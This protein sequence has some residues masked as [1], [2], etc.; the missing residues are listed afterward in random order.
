M[1]MPERNETQPKT[2]PL[3]DSEAEKGIIS[4]AMQDYSYFSQLAGTG[5]NA[6]W[7]ASHEASYLWSA[8]DEL[9]QP[10]A[11]ELTTFALE[12]LPALNAMPEKRRSAILDYFYSAG[13][14]ATPFSQ[15]E[16]YYSK[17][18]KAYQKRLLKQAA[19]NLLEASTRD[20]E[21][22]K[23]LHDL[24]ETVSKVR[25]VATPFEV[26]HSSVLAEQGIEYF[27]K[28]LDRTVNENFM[29][30]EQAGLNNVTEGGMRRGEMTLIKAVTSAGKSSL[31]QREAYVQA[32]K[33]NRCVIYFS[34]EM[35]RFKWLARS[36][37]QDMGISSV[38]LERGKFG[39]WKE[40]VFNKLN[41]LKGTRL[42]LV[43]DTET[44]LEVIKR[45]CE[46]VARKEGAIDIVVVDYAQL[47]RDDT[48]KT[49]VERN[50]RISAALVA[51]KN[52][53]NCHVIGIVKLSRSGE[54]G[55]SSY[56]EY[57]ADNIWLLENEVTKE[58]LPSH[59]KRGPVKVTIQKQRYA[60]SGQEVELYYNGA[61]SRFTDV[62][63]PLALP[64]TYYN[65]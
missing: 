27:S 24:E 47:V 23:D 39:Y 60:A 20:D 21:T 5:I 61:W 14:L 38:A 43:D 4:L 42:Y 17:L 26:L 33:H 63:E 59:Q 28:C 7:F 52:R 12:N 34:L 3:F 44:T 62:D 1:T 48:G 55:E 53:F 9:Y 65:D 30:Y 35:S 10:P 31:A 15:M 50:R 58:N 37:Q 32:V 18:L 57:D 40:N 36:I 25:K 51:L 46:Y 29:V 11:M 56:Y 16:R 8:F 19:L 13:Y 41:Q 6:A 64:E 45:T 22:D 2:L 49:D 54:I